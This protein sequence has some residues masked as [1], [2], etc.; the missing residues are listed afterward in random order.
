MRFVIQRNDSTCYTIS[1]FQ[2]AM[3]LHDDWGFWHCLLNSAT[4]QRYSSVEFE[5]LQFCHMAINLLGGDKTLYHHATRQC[6]PGG[7]QNFKDC[8]K[9]RFN[10]SVE[11]WTFI[12]VPHGNSSP[13]WRSGLNCATWQSGIWG[14]KFIR[15]PTALKLM[16][17]THD[18]K[19]ETKHLINMPESN[20]ILNDGEYWFPQSPA[21]SPIAGYAKLCCKV[22]WIIILK[23][24]VSISWTNYSKFVNL[25]GLVSNNQI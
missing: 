18:V 10:S 5:L 22:S 11:M 19:L 21:S 6:L 16:I 2:P 3:D 1:W 4:W 8:A 14:L 12:V 13:R 20:I 25:H 15:L 17:I 9:R 7:M 23:E 24:H